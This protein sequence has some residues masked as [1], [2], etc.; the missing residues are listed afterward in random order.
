MKLPPFTVSVKA[1]LPATALLGERVLAVGTGLGA[2]MVNVSALEVPPPGA[3]DRRGSRPRGRTPT[4]P[5]PRSTPGRD[6][7]RAQ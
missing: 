4:V 3:G 2:V 7:L 1:G 6:S 5:A